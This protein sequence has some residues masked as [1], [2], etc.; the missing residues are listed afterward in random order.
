MK[1]IVLEMV[2]RDELHVNHQVE[3]PQ[4]LVEHA[5]ALPLCIQPPLFHQ[6]VLQ[7]LLFFLVHVWYRIVLRGLE[8]GGAIYTALRS[9]R[10][11]GLIVHGGGWSRV[12]FSALMKATA[13]FERVYANVRELQKL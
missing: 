10:G 2:H 8:L 6:L 12:V 4:Q 5:D 7:P 9:S 3:L 11:L 13:R 1:L